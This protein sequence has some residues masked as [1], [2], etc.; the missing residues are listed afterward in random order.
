MPYILPYLPR[1]LKLKLEQHAGGFGVPKGLPRDLPA[2]S[3]A[4]S[5]S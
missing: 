1:A 3:P 2:Y 5:S 4:S